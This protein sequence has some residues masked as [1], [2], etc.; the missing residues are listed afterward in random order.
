MIKEMFF[1]IKIKLKR[2]FG[3][4]EKPITYPL[5][6]YNLVLLLCQHVLFIYVSFYIHILVGLCWS[7]E[8]HAFKKKY[9]YDDSMN[10]WN[11]MSIPSFVFNKDFLRIK[12]K[13]LCFLF[14]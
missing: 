6:H 10:H 2:V 12:R 4:H 9:R 14:F 11:F 7:F 3:K 13:K 8:H 5:T 1:F